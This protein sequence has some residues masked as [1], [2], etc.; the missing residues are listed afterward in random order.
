MPKFV[1]VEFKV[2]VELD[3][4]ESKTSGGI[5]LHDVEMKQQH[6]V[7]AKLIAVGGNAF[8]DWKPPVP[9]VGDRVVVNKFSGQ[10]ATFDPVRGADDN[11][12]RL[13]TDKDIV[14]ILQDE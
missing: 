4:V 9:K 13:V 14:C 1:P 11:R 2:L 6:Q 12:L 5:I 10:H 7:N 3:P 8:E